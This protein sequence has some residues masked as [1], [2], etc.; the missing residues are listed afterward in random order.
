MILL[1][2][3]CLGLAIAVLIGLIIFAP[4]ISIGIRILI[5]LGVALVLAITVTL[6]V[7]YAAYQLPPGATI[8]TPIP[9]KKEK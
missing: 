3:G 8:I 4:Q 5:S 9:E 1:Y 7:Y 2:A 6:W